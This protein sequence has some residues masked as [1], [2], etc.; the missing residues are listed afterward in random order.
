MVDIEKYWATQA[1]NYQK[2]IKVIEGPNEP[3]ITFPLILEP[4]VPEHSKEAVLEEARKL[5]A[6][7]GDKDLHSPI[8]QLL[9]AHGGAVLFKHLPLKTADDFSDF[10]HAL[11]G[12]G[13]HA[14][15]H[16]E[17]VGMEVLRRPQ[18]KNVLTANEGP[19]SHFIGWHNEYAV[20]P[21]HP[22][23]LALYCNVKPGAGGETSVSNS[24]ALYDR[25]K[26]DAPGFVEGCASKGLVYHIPHNAEQVSG[27]VGGNGLYKDSAFGPKAGE[28]LP[29]TEEGR[30]AMVEAKIIDL[31]ERGGWHKNIDLANDKEPVWR[32]RGFDWT[33]QEN[34]DLDV[35]H[36]VSGCREHPVT[37]QP[38]I[39]NALSTR[40][41]NAVAN[42]TFDPPF[43]FKRAD[44]TE[45]V[46]IPPHFA[47][48]KKDE[49]V[50]R[51]WLQKMDEW[52]HKLE[53]SITWDAGDV[54]LCDNFAVQHA[55]WGWEGDRK[56][57]A[58][59]WDQP[60]LEAIPL[61]A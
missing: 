14:W 48:I 57:M 5:G 47:G 10:M 54:L 21:V 27:I 20:S 3:T 16:H 23:Y 19:P 43:T 24:I 9:D 34:G 42:D 38:G 53:S 46:S 35:V 15:T 29:E 4:K 7:T 61:T 41:T 59:F 8:R 44:G 28:Q 51:E 30:R 40:Y 45:G 12:K 11:A 25:L 60:G 56:V 33:W 13:E 26:K 36:R 32:R 39:F 49:P 17:H 37:K 50:P 22:H 6:Q 2:K 58:S 18:A 31:A 52:Q 55:R 1:K